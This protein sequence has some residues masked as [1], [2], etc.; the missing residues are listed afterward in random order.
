MN[1]MPALDKAVILTGP[2]FQ[3]HDVIYCQYRV[4]EEWGPDAVDVATKDAKVVY[5][6]SGGVSVP[7]DK[8]SR[9]LVRFEDLSP[10]DYSLCL[11]TGGYEAPDR[12][13]QDKAATDFVRAMHERNRCVAALCHGPWIAS[14]AEI[15]D[16]KQVSS[17][18]GIVDDMRHAG[19]IIVDK[20]V[21][22]DGNLVTSRYYA[23]AGKFMRA[24]FA[25]VAELRRS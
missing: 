18:V 24:A 12:V 15:L 14:S 25:V 22:V 4:A 2:G 17:Y 23:H 1:N 3:E 6:R 9:P 20:D 7:L 21:V 16:G 13:R 5:G 19:A 8:T 11:L 10:D